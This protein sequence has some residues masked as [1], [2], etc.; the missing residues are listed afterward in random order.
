MR[1]S[2][3]TN[4]GA[5]S[6]VMM[7]DFLR[8]HKRVLG[9]SDCLESSTGCY[10]KTSDALMGWEEQE[11]DSPIKYNVWKQ[12]PQSTLITL[13]LDPSMTSDTVKK[14]RR[15]SSMQSLHKSGLTLLRQRTLF[16]SSFSVSSPSMVECLSQ[17]TSCLV[18]EQERAGSSLEELSDS[19]YSSWEAGDY[20]ENSD[21]DSGVGTLTRAHRDEAV[22]RVLALHPHLHPALR[23]V[24][25][26]YSV[27]GRA[28]EG[29]SN[30]VAGLE[31]RLCLRRKEVAAAASQLRE[32]K[33]GVEADLE[34]LEGALVS[35]R[36]VRRLRDFS[37]DLETFT[38]LMVRGKD[39]RLVELQGWMKG[40]EEE[41]A[42][43]V[44]WELGEGW[45]GVWRE[46]VRM[47]RELV[48]K[49]CRCEEERRHIEAQLA[50]LATL[51][52]VM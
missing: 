14:M 16:R 21:N 28:G 41:L 52:T 26:S 42:R 18:E 33:R 38:S 48:T 37:R 12:D 3:N 23:K 19:G 31:Q 7:L 9:Q 45:Q 36:T 44:L 49:L 39:S 43:A 29:W 32:E 20:R 22:S 2:H 34:K 47:K 30:P 50:V 46:Y 17:S 4:K 6:A 15:Q 25:L 10:R 24:L 13:A 11:T 1:G 35:H 5:E 40:R 8:R 27:P 51:R